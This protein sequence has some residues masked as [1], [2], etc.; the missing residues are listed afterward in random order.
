MDAE[1]FT[2]FYN[3]K[4][5]SKGEF[6]SEISQTIIEEEASHIEANENQAVPFNSLKKETAYPFSFRNAR[7]KTADKSEPSVDMNFSI[8]DPISV[9]QQ[10][11]EPECDLNPFIDVIA[12]NDSFENSKLTNKEDP[13][14]FKHSVNLSKNLPEELPQSE[15]KPIKNFL[16]KSDEE[17]EKQ[18]IGQ[19]EFPQMVV[20]KR[21]PEVKSEISQGFASEF[22]I[23]SEDLRTDLINNSEK[24]K[25]NVDK[26]F[27]ISDE[28]MDTK[29][30]IEINKLK[31]ELYQKVPLK[32]SKAFSQEPELEMAK[33][34][35]D[36]DSASDSKEQS[37]L[38]EAKQYGES[39]CSHL[40]NLS[41]DHTGN[42]QA[43]LSSQEQVTNQPS[44]NLSETVQKNSSE[45][46]SHDVVWLESF[47]EFPKDDAK[48][49]LDKESS[50]LPNQT[51]DM[52]SS[53][54][55]G[56]GQDGS[57]SAIY[58]DND[59]VPSS[60]LHSIS[61]GSSIVSSFSVGGDN[62]P[63]DL[64][65]V[66]KRPLS[67]QFIKSSSDMDVFL[68]HGS[69]DRKLERPTHMPSSIASQKIYN[70]NH[71]S[72]TITRSGSLNEKHSPPAVVNPSVV[73]LQSQP[74]VV[75]EWERKLYGRSGCE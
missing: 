39:D 35:F 31:I 69:T 66:N 72:P 1:K 67:K 8:I 49:N 20:T 14:S 70:E 36:L 27:H 7:A 50:N 16:Q 17:N 64:T 24:K 3:P 52:N 12:T 22:K 30:E 53:Q 42:T 56:E 18:K 28:E 33:E 71:D 23:Y 63:S 44:E 51:N 62:P 54:N 5:S 9:Q 74:T 11:S 15:T 65:E 58:L 41:S 73:P 21:E 38:L 29:P 47:V 45:Q 46:G 10:S 26:S 40:S 4:I 19:N 43:G 48:H 57:D 75:D 68:R 55:Q 6:C 13:S 60:H 37:S 59:S 2:S 32:N 34:Y 61:N 25:V